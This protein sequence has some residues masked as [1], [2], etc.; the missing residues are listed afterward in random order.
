MRS[1][2]HQQL[3]IPIARFRAFVALLRSSLMARER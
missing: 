3:R 2:H 1:P